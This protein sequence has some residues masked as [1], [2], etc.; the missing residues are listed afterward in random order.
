MAYCNRIKEVD[1]ELGEYYICRVY[2]EKGFRL[3]TPLSNDNLKSE[4]ILL[5]KCFGKDLLFKDGFE[6][7]ADVVESIFPFRKSI[8]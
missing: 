2:D 5:Q 3:Q 6:D 1:E 7:V 8:R 4:L